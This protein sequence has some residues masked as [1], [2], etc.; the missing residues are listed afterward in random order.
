M[1]TPTYIFPHMTQRNTEINNVSHNKNKRQILYW[2]THTHKLTMSLI[3][4]QKVIDCR[5]TCEIID[6]W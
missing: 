4:F 3:I 2:D 5:E 1:Q 6:I